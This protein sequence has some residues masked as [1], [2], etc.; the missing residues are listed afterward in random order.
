M[1]NLHVLQ[2]QWLVTA[3][4]SGLTVVFAAVLTYLA[5]WKP[6]SWREDDPD[7]DAV[8][9]RSWQ[10]IPW[11]LIMTYVGIILYEIGYTVLFALYPPNY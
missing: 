6:R 8:S 11:I 1:F 5:I 4:V 10:Y 9:D 7:R 3:L 2:H